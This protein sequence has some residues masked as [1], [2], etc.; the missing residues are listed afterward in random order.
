MR[1][2]NMK[3]SIIA[4][5]LVCFAMSNA[6]AQG[7]SKKGPYE[8]NK[9]WDNWFVSLGV[10]GQ[11]YFGEDDEYGDFGKRITPA[12]DI[13]VGKWITPAVGVRMQFNG[14]NG[15]GFSYGDSPY[16]YGKRN[17][18]YLYK[19]KFNLWNLHADVMYDLITAIKGY[20]EERVYSVI[21]YV[22]FGVAH[23]YKGD[24]PKNTDFSAN[25]GI[26]NRFRVSDAI[27]INLELKGYFVNQSMDG[28]IRGCKGEGVAQAT[29]GITYKFNKR[30]FNRVSACA[31]A[32]YTPYTKRIGALEDEL[33]AAQAR[34][35]DL[36]DQLAACRN[37][38]PETVE[39]AAGPMAVFFTIGKA[40]LTDKDMINLGYL[41]D[42]IKKTPN[43]KY[44][45]IGSADKGTGSAKFNQTLSQKRAEKVKSIL[46][47]KFGVDASQLEVVAKGGV[48]NQDPFS[49]GALNRNVIVI[50]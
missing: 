20:N 4:L 3:Q 23:M 12:F 41:A 42:A 7:E 15:K 28:V 11:V 44:K 19:T 32:D 21:P 39:S 16:A 45:I 40:D 31:P 18:D 6:V 5:F 34:E 10:G 24:R 46:V 26:I 27:D 33:A 47:D 17:S 35:K 29:V 37:R 9:F 36:A 2:L 50:E 43:K 48:A 8:T 13:A 22:G 1:L 14:F 25:L 30:N 38:K 49:K